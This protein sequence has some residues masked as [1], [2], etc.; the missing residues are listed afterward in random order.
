MIHAKIA[1]TTPKLYDD[2]MTEQRVID[3][4]IK[5][6]H[7]ELALESLQQLVYDQQK[8]IDKLEARMANLGKRFDG[9]LDIGPANEKPP[10]Y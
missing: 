2:A 1:F 10:H 3:L 8:A 5:I 7:Q 4:E 6:S 9:G